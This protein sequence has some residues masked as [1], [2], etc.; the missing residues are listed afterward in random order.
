W[1]DAYDEVDVQTEEIVDLQR[2]P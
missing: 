2:G 1:F